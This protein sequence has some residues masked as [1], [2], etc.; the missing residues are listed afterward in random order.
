MI[1]ADVRKRLGQ[2]SLA[3]TL[4]D[5]GFIC[6]LGKNGSGKSSLMRGIAGLYPLDEGHVRISGV[7]VTRSPPESRGVVLV[8]PGSQIPHLSVDA[9][10]AWGSR[11]R[12]VRVP[13]ERLS[14]VKSTLGIDFAGKVSQLSLGMRERVALA[15][16]FLSSPKVILVDEAFS[17]LHER[18]DF[19]ATYRTLTNDAG[20]DLIFSTQDGSDSSLADHAYVIA[21]GKTEKQS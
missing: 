2:F 6:L 9:H 4:A 14:A 3:A 7:D 5:D 16:A 10:L 12:K 21:E 20:I 15:T 19:I 1:E 11:L 17:N 8:T 13:D 18:R